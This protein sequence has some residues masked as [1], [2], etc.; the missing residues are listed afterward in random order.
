MRDQGVGA[1]VWEAKSKL[2]WEAIA[3][4][5][6]KEKSEGRYASILPLVRWHRWEGVSVRY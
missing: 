4:Y 2:T 6:A 3:R 1:G 5:S